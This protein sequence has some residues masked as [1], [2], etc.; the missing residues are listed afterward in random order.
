M[1]YRIAQRE[2]KLKDWY[3]CKK[4]NLKLNEWKDI[5]NKRRALAG[6]KLEIFK[7]LTY[8]KN[9]EWLNQNAEED[10]IYIWYNSKTVEELKALVE[11]F[12]VNQRIIGDDIGADTSTIN[13]TINKIIEERKDETSQNRNVSENIVALL[14]YYFQDE[15]NKRAIYTPKPKTRKR[16]RFFKTVEKEKIEEI[17]EELKI[18]QPTIFATSEDYSDSEEKEDEIVHPNVDEIELNQNNINWYNAYVET[19]NELIE[20][21]KQLARLN[22]LID[23]ARK[24]ENYGI[25]IKGKII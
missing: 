23:N 18:E 10:K 24:S 9:K 7:N 13:R 16:R 12:K 25:E 19:F 15:N 8:K 1:N 14:Y 21:K 2:A 17:K 5:K 4:L 3:I 20:T 11:E 6:E 22:Y